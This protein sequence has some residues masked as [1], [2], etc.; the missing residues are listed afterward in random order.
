MAWRAEG[1]STSSWSMKATMA[2]EAAA[3]PALVALAIPPFVAVLTIVMRGSAA[4]W[5]ARI[6]AVSGAV[7]Q[8]STQTSSQRP[9][10]WAVTLAMACSSHAA[11]VL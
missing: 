10:H 6:A 2:C 3:T 9:Y 1:S 8:S 4:A 5:R 7:E 11:G